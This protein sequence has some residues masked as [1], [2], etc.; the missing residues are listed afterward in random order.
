MNG[1]T[2]LE[3]I[4]CFVAD[5]L[6]FLVRS[7]VA[8]IFAMIRWLL[9]CFSMKEQKKEEERKL[10]GD[11]KR[12]YLRKSRTYCENISY[13]NPYNNHDHDK[14]PHFSRESAELEVARMKRMQ[15]PGHERL[16]VYYNE[17]LGA[18]FVGRSKFKW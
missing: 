11:D 7:F 14:Q 1:N 6:C 13:S 5:L 18:W 15:L 10:G 16:N 4:E 9:R 17:E 8:I 3:K 2:A 12:D